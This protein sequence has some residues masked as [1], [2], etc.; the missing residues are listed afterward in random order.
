MQLTVD[1]ATIHMALALYYTDEPDK[2]IKRMAKRYRRNTKQ[3]EARR[4][5][6]AIIKDPHPS[7]SVEE[8]YEERYLKH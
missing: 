5:Y 6:K 1:Q 8:V 2:Q 7:Q 3:P 4:I